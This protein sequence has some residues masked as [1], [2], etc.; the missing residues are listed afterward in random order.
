MCITEQLINNQ[1]SEMKIILFSFLKDFSIKDFRNWK[2]SSFNKITLNDAGKFKKDFVINLF[3]NVDNFLEFH[4]EKQSLI[5]DKKII[6]ED[7]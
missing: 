3:G 5:A 4:K 6:L 7:E 1:C 2:W